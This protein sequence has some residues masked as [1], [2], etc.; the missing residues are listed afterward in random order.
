MIPVLLQQAGIISPAVTGPLPREAPGDQLE[1]AY[2]LLTSFWARRNNVQKEK[3]LTSLVSGVKQR[4]LVSCSLEV[5][6]E[7]I[8]G[9]KQLLISASP[10][11][12]L[13]RGELLMDQMTDGIWWLLN[14]LQI[15]PFPLS[16]LSLPFWDGCFGLQ[17]RFLSSLR[18][19]LPCLPSPLASHCSHFQLCSQNQLGDDEL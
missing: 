10:F 2:S 18:N 17:L 15:P 19:V 7:F 9:Y 4:E 1:G 13:L 5:C 3:Q 16:C 14:L 11:L 8:W 6:V 12:I